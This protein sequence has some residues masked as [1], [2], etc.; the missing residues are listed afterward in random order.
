MRSVRQRRG[1]GEGHEVRADG[2][3]DK[4]AI[5]NQR[6]TANVDSRQR[7][8]ESDRDCWPGVSYKPAIYGRIQLEH[9]PRGLGRDKEAAEGSSLDIAAER[10]RSIDGNGVDGVIR[11]RSG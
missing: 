5:Q 7:I 10:D 4:R 1:R 2:C 8:V 6:G 3:G 11:E 9:R